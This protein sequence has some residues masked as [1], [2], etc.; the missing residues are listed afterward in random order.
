MKKNLKI[1]I[2]SFLALGLVTATAVSAHQGPVDSS[3]ANLNKANNSANYEDRAQRMQNFHENMSEEDLAKMTQIHELMVSGEYEEAL[4]IKNDLGM[5]QGM[6]RGM[7]QGMRQGHGNRANGSM[8][9]FIDNN[10]DG[11]C[12]HMEDIE[13]N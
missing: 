10:N 1:A 5:G 6:R 3:Q 2:F 7:G 12:D 4:K 13:I 9:N 8:P 11:L